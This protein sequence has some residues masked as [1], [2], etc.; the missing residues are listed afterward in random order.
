MDLFNVEGAA[1][2]KKLRK[3]KNFFAEKFDKYK[4]LYYLCQYKRY[5]TQGYYFLAWI[6]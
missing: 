4:I 2:K 5:A 3:N 6:L 1:L